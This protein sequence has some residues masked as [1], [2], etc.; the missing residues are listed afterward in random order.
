[1]AGF[2]KVEGFFGHYKYIVTIVV[3]VAFI[4]FLS[5][6]SILKIF[7][8]SHE[9][10]LLQEEIDKYRAQYEEDVYKL[11]EI[12]HN[13]YMVEKIARERYFMKEYDE[14]IFILSTDK[15]RIAE[16]EMAEKAKRNEKAE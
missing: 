11:R 16:K 6:N 15:Q 9:K 12:Q 8:L 4:G 1:M 2:N 10:D 13:R 7:Q 5:Q 14:D 3:G